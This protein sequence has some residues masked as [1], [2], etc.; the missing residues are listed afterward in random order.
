LRPIIAPIFQLRDYLVKRAALQ[1]D[2]R[3]SPSRFLIQRYLE[4]GFPEDAFI[5]LENGI[6]VTRF[7]K[8]DPVSREAGPLRVTYLGSLAW[9]K[10]VHILVEAVRGLPAE[11]INL[12]IYGGEETFPDYVA[13]LFKLADPY[14]TS[15][16]GRIPNV[17][18]GRVL[19]ATD[20]LVV[21]SL[22]Y[23]NS[24]IV[25]REAFAAG[26][27]VIA[28]NLGALR[29]KVTHQVDGLLVEPENVEHLRKTLL[30]LAHNGKA[31]EELRLGISPILSTPEHIS[32]VEK[33]Y[34]NLARKTL[35]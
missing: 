7:S 32:R 8:P 18:V 15:F 27:V 20:V 28:S 25:I 3:I 14:N 24:P 2:M 29:E 16:K 22:W 10:G 6:D 21:P 26:V 5:W 23:E 17:E 12:S 30:E 11:E 31:L 1:C 9:Q 19:A 4:A 35:Q 34:Q 33:L 13:S